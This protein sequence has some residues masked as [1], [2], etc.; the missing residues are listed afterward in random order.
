M[1]NKKQFYKE[2]GR[3]LYAV[4]M[5]DG[6]VKKKEIDALHD[7]VSRELAPFENESDSS[8]MNEA[9]YTDF[10]FDEYLDHHV[11]IES[12]HD[13]FVK[14]LQEHV[15]DIDPVLVDKSLKAIDKIATAFRE[16][17]AKEKAMIHK[18]K[19]EIKEISDLF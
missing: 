7:F 10:E 6:K 16:M 18:I 11:T 3:L 17:N 5:V 9:F 19:T 8:G 12:A 2:L 15:T 14:Y 13:S 1:L 4:A